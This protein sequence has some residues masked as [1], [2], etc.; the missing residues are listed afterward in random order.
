MSLPKLTFPLTID[1]TTAEYW[2][3]ADGPFA[4][5]EATTEF[6][7]GGIQTDAQV[8]P[9]ALLK[10]LERCLRAFG[11]HLNAYIQPPQTTKEEFEQVL[12]SSATSAISYRYRTRP[13]AVTF[14]RGMTF[15]SLRDF[16]Y[17]DLCNAA[18]SGSGPR[19]CRL[20]GQ[21][22]FHKHGDK[23]I[24]CERIAPGETDKTCREM[25]ARTVFEKKIQDEEPWKLYKRAY[26]KYYARFMKGNMSKEDFKAW[27]EQATELRD[28]AILRLGEATDP[29]QKAQAI[30]KLREDLNRE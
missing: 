13:G 1:C 17:T 14:L 18:L 26:K 28:I 19:Q 6:F 23:S 10:E 27:V 12:S 25:G 21:W 16:L 4:F 5:G 3:G 7:C 9:A 29:E 8:N 22:F 11:G 2:I 24:Y 30:E 20:C 15:S